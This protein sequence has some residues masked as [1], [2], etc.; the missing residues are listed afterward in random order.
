ML[1]LL[2]L[3]SLPLSSL[4]CLL[5]YPL[6]SC[7]YG[8]EGKTDRVLATRARHVPESIM[9]SLTMLTHTFMISIAPT[10]LLCNISHYKIYRNTTHTRAHTHTHTHT[11]SYHPVPLWLCAAALLLPPTTLAEGRTGLFCSPVTC[12]R[13]NDIVPTCCA[14]PAVSPLAVFGSCDYFVRKV[15]VV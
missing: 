7:C 15:S 11:V 1:Q 10:Y 4:L 9:V 13:D 6:V 3:P 2:T 8:T 12:G 14:E 5:D